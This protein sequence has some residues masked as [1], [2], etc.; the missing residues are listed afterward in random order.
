MAVEV[1]GDPVYNII[2]LVYPGPGGTETLAGLP[3]SGRAPCGDT[4][5]VGEAM[6]NLDTRL[7]F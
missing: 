2:G 4:H 7:D 5:G 3:D 6:P 1:W